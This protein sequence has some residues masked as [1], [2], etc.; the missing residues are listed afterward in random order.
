MTIF[1]HAGDPNFCAIC[2]GELEDLG[3]VY[4]TSEGDICTICGHA[5]PEAII[6]LETLGRLAWFN[7]GD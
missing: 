5:H 3:P 1:K 2:G 7:E 4:M 6:P